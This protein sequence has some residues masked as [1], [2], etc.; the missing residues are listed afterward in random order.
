VKYIFAAVYLLVLVTQLPHIWYAYAAIERSGWVLAHYTALAAAVAF[1]ASI[2]LFTYRV[3]KGARRRWT[4]RG[5]AFFIA[6]SVVAN[7]YYYDWLPVV[8]DRLMPVFATIALPL[9]LALFAEEFGAEVRLSERRSKREERQPDAIPVQSDAIP[10]QS[11]N[12]TKA[13]TVT[14]LSELHPDWSRLQLA[15]YAG[16]SL[17]TVSRALN[18]GDHNGG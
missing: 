10:V 11:D 9:S 13:S 14:R 15:E 4:A 2:G 8:F 17:S 3:V 6:A 7:A 16:C 18:N 5:L 12:Q 1:E